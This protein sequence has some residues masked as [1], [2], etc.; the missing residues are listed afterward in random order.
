MEEG[1]VIEAE[2]LIAVAALGGLVDRLEALLTTHV[3]E[4][5]SEL[6]VDRGLDARFALAE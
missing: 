6:V 2:L 1:G 4:V 3:L 5:R